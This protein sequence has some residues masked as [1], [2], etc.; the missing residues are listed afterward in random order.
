[1]GLTQAGTELAWGLGQGSLHASSR[2]TRGSG[3]SRGQTALHLPA[4]GW[5]V[6]SSPTFGLL[7][8]SPQIGG[9]GKI[10]GWDTAPQMGREVSPHVSLH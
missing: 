6:Q 8:P 3:K 7:S 4:L 10:T 9:V 1:M 2:Q 5:K